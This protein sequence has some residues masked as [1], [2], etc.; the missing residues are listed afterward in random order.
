MTGPLTIR[1]AP[2]LRKWLVA[3]F[4]AMEAFM[5]ILGAATV[6]HGSL[7]EGAVASGVAVLLPLLCWRWVGL[8]VTGA[9]DR[10]IVRGFLTTRSI[11]SRDIA[12]FRVGGHRRETPGVAVRTV[13]RDGSTVVLAATGFYFRARQEVEGYRAELEDW[14]LSPSS[15]ARLASIK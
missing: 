15:T 13:L 14:R 8:A 5:I 10:L 9:A 4:A 1:L 11:P 2:A 3:W 12:G 6:A 7:S